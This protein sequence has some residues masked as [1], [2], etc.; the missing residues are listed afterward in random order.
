MDIRLPEFPA[1]RD[2]A[3]DAASRRGKPDESN[4]ADLL[5]ASLNEPQEKPRETVADK[6]APKTTTERD[7]DRDIAEPVAADTDRRETADAEAEAPAVVA[8]APER[9]EP[10]PVPN[11]K[12]ATQIAAPA[13]TV[14]TPDTPATAP[15]APQPQASVPIAATQPLP[16]ADLPNQP[17]SDKI[18]A[19]SG[20]APAPQQPGPQPAAQ[21]IDPVAQAASQNA[22]TDPTQQ[23]TFGTELAAAGAKPVEPS[24]VQPKS[25]AKNDAKPVT[26]DIQPTTITAETTAPIAV[27]DAT[28]PN[29]DVT[30]DPRHAKGEGLTP[31]P[32]PATAMATTSTTAPTD[33]APDASEDAQIVAILRQGAAATAR[34]ASKDDAGFVATDDVGLKDLGV[35]PKP[36]PPEHAKADA[37]SRPFANL[38]PGLGL[39]AQVTAQQTPDQANA[40]ERLAQLAA[41]SGT[42]VS[43][44]ARKEGET[45]KPADAAAAPSRTDQ[46]ATIEASSP[47]PATAD[48]GAAMAAARSARPAFQPV[49]AQVAAHVAQAAIEGNDRINIR[50]TPAE[51]G[52]IDVRLEFAPDGRIQAVFAADRPQTVELLQRDAR[53]LE[54]AL[55]DAGLRADSGSLSFNLRGDGRG[56]AQHGAQSPIGDG[57]EE[58]VVER[59]SPQLQA[60]SAGSAGSGRLDIRI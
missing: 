56:G 38:A 16:P 32:A 54:R 14:E 35:D 26:V 36:T 52:R 13:E 58:A 20:L 46:T 18:S 6:R 44:E 1:S 11:D 3:P 57:S 4:F 19:Q 15:V 7:H 34:P 31:S 55:Q 49:I 17:A 47:R 28:A 42:D 50:L 24:A 45:P 53:E 2:N 60:Y 41:A 21:P 9:P 33:G 51:L 40:A 30:R 10:P 37:P 22:A 23:P 48:V 25:K 27:P 59:V 43:A 5:D 39:A 29:G 8:H 12:V